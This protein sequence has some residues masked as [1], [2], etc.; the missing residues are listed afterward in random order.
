MGM[1]GKNK[2]TA[3]LIMSYSYKALTNRSCYFSFAVKL[4]KDLF[5]TGAL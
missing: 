4:T 1:K 5:F 2:H 3:P